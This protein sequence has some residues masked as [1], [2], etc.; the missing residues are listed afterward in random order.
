MA[1]EAVIQELLRYRA[2]LLHDKRLIPDY[3]EADLFL[4]TNA[5]AFLMAA[6]TD[7]GASAFERVWK[8][9]L[10][11]KRHLS[12]L[13]ASKF[14]VM[15]EGE[16]ENALLSLTP[17]PRFPATF[18]KTI[19]Q[20]AILVTHELGGNARLFWEGQSVRQVKARLMNLWGVGPGIANMTIRILHD[21]LDWDPGPEGLRD[22][23]VKADVHVKRVF[24]RSGLT[25]SP[26]DEYEPVRVARALSPRFPGALDRPAWGIGRDW[27][28]P[29]APNCRACR[30]G[31]VCPRIG[32]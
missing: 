14:A 22:I 23:D 18:A 29:Q 20:L 24:Y 17:K 31:A 6:C 1:K 19:K 12:H 8:M 4:R 16:I 9:P 2:E 28:R 11:L 30:L 7:R 25:S 21:D 32:L 15:T 13:E 27:C 5:F 10:R 3:E 26:S